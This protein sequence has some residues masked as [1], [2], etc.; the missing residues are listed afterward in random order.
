MVAQSHLIQTDLFKANQEI[1][2]LTQEIERLLIARNAQAR[3]ADHA[4]KLYHQLEAQLVHPAKESFTLIQQFQNPEDRPKLDRDMDEHINAGWEIAHE[5]YNTLEATRH[6]RI[7]R[8]SRTAPI[9][10]ATDQRPITE[11]VSPTAPADD[12]A[13]PVYPV[14][15]VEFPPVHSSII[16]LWNALYQMD[17]YAEL[18]QHW[19]KLPEYAPRIY[20]ILEA[21]GCDMADVKI[22]KSFRLGHRA[23]EWTLKVS[24]PV[25]TQIAPGTRTA[26]VVAGFGN[27]VQRD[28]REFIFDLPQAWVSPPRKTITASSMTIMGDDTATPAPASDPV[29]RDRADL[30]AMVSDTEITH[31]AFHRALINSRLPH[32]E[33]EELLIQS[34]QIRV[35]GRIAAQVSRV[36]SYQARPINSYLT[37]GK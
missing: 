14:D 22:M 16:G 15:P 17:R 19:S 36:P 20:A 29:A 37:G 28:G 6:I 10:P 3:R 33:Q 21:A 26:L 8:F 2:A 13:L 7:V 30:N 25:S 12:P 11:Q 24:F 34:R 18:V 31:D 32:N 9:E 27:I 5:T 4:E 35:G 23:D 1:A